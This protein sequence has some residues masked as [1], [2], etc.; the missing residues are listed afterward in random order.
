MQDIKAEIERAAT[1]GGQRISI[2]PNPTFGQRSAPVLFPALIPQLDAQSLS[3]SSVDITVSGSAAVVAAGAVKPTAA[4]AAITPRQIG[5]VAGLATVNSEIFWESPDAIATLIST[6]YASCLS[7]EDKVANAALDTAAAAAV[8][9]SDWI[10]AIALGQATVAAAGGAPQL[11]VV[12]ATVWPVLAKEI[13]TSVGLTTPSSEAI[14]S[15]LG[16]RIVLSPEGTKAFVVD[17]N[18]AVHAVRD[19]GFIID[20]SSGAANN[21]VTVVVDLVASTFVQVAGHVCEIAKTVA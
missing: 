19:V 11:V 8:P 5:K 2:G 21:K 17:P 13:A 12:P 7:E 15:V 4:A 16:S 6:I 14:A 3:F 18:A 10:S 20:A 1:S 9:Q